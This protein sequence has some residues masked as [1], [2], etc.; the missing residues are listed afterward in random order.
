MRL[1]L[2]IVCIS[3]I[4]SCSSDSDSDSAGKCSALE[5]TD[6][7]VVVA[8][9]IANGTPCE[10]LNKSPVVVVLKNMPDGRTGFCSGTM[11]SPNKVLTAAHCLEGAGSIDI[12]FGTVTEKFAYVTASSWNIHPSFTRNSNGT[13][14]NDIGIVHSP[15]PLPVPN[16]PILASS[17]PQVGSKASIFGYGITSGAA[18]DLGKLRAGAMTIAGVDSN[19][20]YANYEASSSNVCSGDSGGPLLLQ[21]GNQQAII[22]TTSYG[23]SVNC[24]VGELSVFMNIQSPS[25]QSFIRSVAPDARFQ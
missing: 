4:A 6:A 14:V 21:V 12:L 23:N 8:A 9:K 22:G 10:G 3:L 7:T 24:S 13:L 17:T 2:A 1:L 11:L 19:N 20:I 15:I 5:L 16:L 25:M 18:D